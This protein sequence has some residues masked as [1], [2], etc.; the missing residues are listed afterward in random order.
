LTSAF[1]DQLKRG[2]IPIEE[3][4]KLALQI[5]EALEVAHEKGVIHGDLKSADIKVT[6]DGKRFPMMRESG[7]GLSAG[8]GPRKINIVVNWFAEV[9]QRAPVK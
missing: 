2:P 3:S 6:P 1:A 4:L 8:G 5:A 7:T 9:K